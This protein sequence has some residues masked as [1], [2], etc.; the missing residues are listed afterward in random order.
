MDYSILVNK[1]NP[2]PRAHIPNSL[3]DA[4]SKYKENI[5]LDRLAKESFDKLKNEALRY[6]YNIDIVSGYRDYDYQEKI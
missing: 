5:K 2:L 6:G 4:E 1:D 3:V